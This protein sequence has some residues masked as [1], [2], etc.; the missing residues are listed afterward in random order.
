MKPPHA[1]QRQMPSM[2]SEQ[3]QESEAELLVSALLNY[4]VF[5]TE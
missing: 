1:I 5:L 4:N 2:Q 3:S